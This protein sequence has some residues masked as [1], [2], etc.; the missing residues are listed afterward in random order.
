MNNKLKF[1]ITGMSCA[2]CAN[3]I[4]KAVRCVEG[5][6]KCNVNLLTNSMEIEGSAKTETLIGA[7]EGAGYGASVAV[8]DEFI[9]N[10]EIPIILRRVILSVFLLIP[11]MYI[12][13]KMPQPEWDRLKTG[14]ILM[15]FA[16]TVIIINRSFFISGFRGII[17]RATN[18]D[19]LVA[20]GSGVSF[21]YSVYLLLFTG[22]EHFYFESAAAILTFISVGKLLESLSKGKTTDAIKKLMDL[23]PDMATILD[24]QN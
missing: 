8:T 11:I 20:M 24:G 23:N 19:T 2:A 21:V 10:K 12:S 7:V 16:G 15:F 18:M 5:V 1:N 22:T 6:E 14:L 13:V 4:E 9:T 17:N 3:R